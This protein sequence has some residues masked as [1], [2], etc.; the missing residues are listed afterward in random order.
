M[1]A[2]DVHSCFMWPAEKHGTSDEEDSKSVFNG[3]LDVT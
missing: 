3:S 2:H 1:H